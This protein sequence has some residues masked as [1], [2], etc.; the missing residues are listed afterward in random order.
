MYLL[1]L[2]GMRGKGP[3]CLIMGDVLGPWDPESGCWALSLPS[4]NPRASWLT[5]GDSISG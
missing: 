1:L 4:P 2:L 3:S 5:G